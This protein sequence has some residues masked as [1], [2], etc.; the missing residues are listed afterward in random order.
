MARTTRRARSRAVGLLVLAHLA[1]CCSVC[2]AAA[3]PAA[4]GATAAGA[5]SA[6]LPGPAGIPPGLHRR[7]DGAGF[8]SPHE[9]DFFADYKDLVNPPK[10]LLEPNE[11]LTQTPKDLLE[12]PEG[13][14]DTPADLAETPKDLLD[15]N[16]DLEDFAKNGAGDGQEAQPDS[17]DEGGIPTGLG[18][19]GSQGKVGVDKDPDTKAHDEQTDLSLA[20][21][22]KSSDRAREYGGSPEDEA[23]KVAPAAVS[24]SPAEGPDAPFSSPGAGLSSSYEVDLPGRTHPKLQGQAE[25]LGASPAVGSGNKAGI[26]ST[27]HGLRGS[28]LHTATHG[29]SFSCHQHLE[30]SSA[31]LKF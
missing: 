30:H 2:T 31:T 13:L 8:P 12:T 25:G 26:T 17:D 14:T 3:G 27:F 20:K 11:D 7:L 5:A 24:E 16:Q 4:A 21:H 23:A 1:G 15:D 22:L 29:V 18:S 9:D 10:D 28:G 19:T 6:G